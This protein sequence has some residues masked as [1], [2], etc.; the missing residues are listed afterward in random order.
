MGLDFEKR[1]RELEAENDSL[2]SAILLLHRVANLVRGAV[3]LEQTCYALLTGVTAGEGL[4]L[5]RAMLFLVDDTNRN[6]L[7]GVAAVGPENWQEAQRAWRFI[8][9]TGP[10]LETL[11]EAGLHQREMPSTLDERVRALTVN[12]EGN[13][14]VAVALRSGTV[15]ESAG[16]DDLDGLLHL[17][18]AVA[19]PLRGREKVRGVLYADNRFTGVRPSPVSLL[20]FALLADHAGRAIEC[21]RQFEQ[22]ARKARTDALTGLGHHGALMEQL[23]QAVE[24]ARKANELYGV[25]MV[26]LDGFKQVNDTFGHL[27]GDALL[28]GVAARIRAAVRT[29]ESIFRY[30]GEEFTVLLAGADREAAAAVGE[31]L[32]RAVG[33]KPFLLDGRTVVPVTCSVGVAALPEDGNDSETLVAAAD[34]A[35][36]RAKAKGKNRVERAASSLPPFS[37]AS[38]GDGSALCRSRY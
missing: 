31:R 36:L 30:G 21:A 28:A 15:V 8:Q 2:R 38:S 25:V 18:T 32:R 24:R 10:D 12:A 14:P 33:D 22:V 3:E 20:V 37:V 19:A 7:R 11:W 9:D 13:S 6:L 29:T 1:L 17:P 34:H 16:S 26:D 5:N 35:L 4:G 27:V 23:G